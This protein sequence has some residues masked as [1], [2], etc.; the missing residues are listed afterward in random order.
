MSKHVKVDEVLREFDKGI[1]YLRQRIIDLPNK[2]IDESSFNVGDEVWLVYRNEIEKH[3]ID[4]SQKQYVSN[5]G[6]F[7]GETR[8]Y[9]HQAYATK[10]QA[11]LA[12]AKIK[13][14]E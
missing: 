6:S 3:I 7:S 13:R 8:F 1:C 12:L 2:E 5:L 14:G 9:K 10:A 4:D 11:E